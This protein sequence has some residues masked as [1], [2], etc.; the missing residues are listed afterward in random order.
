MADR[1]ERILSGEVAAGEAGLEEGLRPRSLSDFLGQ[2]KAKELLSIYIAAAR[3]RRESLDHV[4]LYGP[5][6]LGKTTLAHIIAAELGVSIRLTSGPALERPGDLAAILTGLTER[7]V[8]F[9]DEIHR[10]PRIVEEILYPAMEDGALDIV[11]GKGPG[12]RSVRLALPAFTLV[13]ATTRAGMLTSPLRDRFGVITRL[14]FY[15]VDDLMSIVRRAARILGVPVEEEA[16]REVARRARGTPRVANRLLR[17]LRDIAQVRAEGAITY[18]VA[19]AALAMLEVDELGLDETDT[20]LLQAIALKYAGGPV[21]LDTLAAATSEAPET[22]EDLH[23]PY[24]MQVG[25]LQRTPR[26]RVITPAA[27]RH[28]GLPVDE[29]ARQARF[30]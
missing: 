22:I 17:R 28:L 6:G 8:L 4:L 10:L 13:G 3:E 21:G 11:I 27:Y 16:G 14:D 30:L 7:D 26:G 5:P 18:E 20:R 12:A 1:P 24:L 19:R 2:P 9:V 15:D 29:S 23:E 25:F